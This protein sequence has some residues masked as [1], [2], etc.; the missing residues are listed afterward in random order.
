MCFFMT[1]QEKTLVDTVEF[2][3][4]RYFNFNS[5]ENLTRLCRF[6]DSLCVEHFEIYND[7]YNFDFDFYNF[8]DFGFLVFDNGEYFYVINQTNGFTLGAS[9][10]DYE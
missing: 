9:K 1:N 10:F 2:L 5:S 6:I 4:Q 3:A 8:S 7:Y